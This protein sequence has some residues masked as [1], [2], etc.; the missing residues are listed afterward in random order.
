MAEELP[1]ALPEVV[2]AMSHEVE[3]VVLEEEEVLPGVE[4]WEEAL[5]VVTAEAEALN[6]RQHLLPMVDS[7]SHPQRREPRAMTSGGQHL[8]PSNLCRRPT[9]L[10][11]TLLV[12]PPGTLTNIS[13]LRVT[14]FLFDS[15]C[16]KIWK[17]GAV[18]LKS[19][20]T[21]F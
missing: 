6:D 9:H 7:M 11:H 10:L 19:G 15:C 14:G 4:V 3:V 12:M 18:T 5:V 17:D 1:E 21:W 2:V 8:L 13:L 20:K 16:F